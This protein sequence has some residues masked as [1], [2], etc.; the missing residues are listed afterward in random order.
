MSDE[1]VNDADLRK[2]IRQANRRLEQK[3]EAERR[4]L[5]QQAVEQ[6]MNEELAEK[7]LESERVA[8][9][10]GEELARD[11]VKEAAAAREQAQS[12]VLLLVM[13]LLILW[14]IAAAIGRPDILRFT[15]GPGTL[16][17]MAPRL[18]DGSSPTDAAGA[19]VASAQRSAGTNMPGVG[20]LAVP[21]ATISPA[22]Q[23]FYDAHGGE[24]VFGRPISNELTVNGRRFQWFERARLE[25]W[26]EYN[27]TDYSVQSGL[28]GYEFTKGLKFPE[29]T[30]Y[31]SQPD[32]RFFPE[33]GHGVAGRFLDF[34][35]AVDGMRVLG[36]PI[37]DQVQESLPD[38]QVYT[39]QYFERGRI[40][41][42]PQQAGTPYEMQMGLLGRA[43]FLKESTPNIIPPPKPTAVPMPQ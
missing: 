8:E 37:S 35:N 21:N 13:L 26:P 6:A 42:H 9:I 1:S 16:P 22:F 17:T 5:I 30:Y 11:P 29:Q 25:Q 7:R 41:Y 20:S 38:K 19:S 33:T 2:A 43:L 10:V 36:Y 15:E 23:A 4:V 27:G 32:N 24:P 14:L 34:W 31:V 18:G 12:A 28:L 39:V 3:S 40:E